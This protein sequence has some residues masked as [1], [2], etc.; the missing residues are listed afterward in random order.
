MARRI[1]AFVLAG[2]L[3]LLVL[4]GAVRQLTRDTVRDVVLSESA[5][6][7]TLRQEFA[8]L[9]QT[10]PPP[11]RAMGTSC[12]PGPRVSY[13]ATESYR[14]PIDVVMRDR[15]ADP[16]RA[17]GFYDFGRS[18]LADLVSMPLPGY[19]ERDE[20]SDRVDDAEAEQLR[21]FLN[22]GTVVVLQFA[23]LRPGT[24]APGS[25]AFFTPGSVT[26]EALLVELGTGNVLCTARTPARNRGEMDF[27]A[28]PASDRA[29]SAQ[30]KLAYDLRGQAATAIAAE[31]AS[32]GVGDFSFNV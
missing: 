8:R 9:D 31:L 22:A 18:T 14:N 4:V 11:G 2:V 12:R 30:E 27:L 5:R 16:L 15:L 26:V 24:L 7:E 13:S 32:R 29:T 3:G 6:L 23:D 1:I 25:S 19:R 21:R 28:S 17:P 20:D 10:L